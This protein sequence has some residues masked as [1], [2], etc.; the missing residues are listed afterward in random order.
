[1]VN[2]NGNSDG[3]FPNLTLPFVVP[4]PFVNCAAAIEFHHGRL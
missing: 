2:G 3:T 4:L 1:M